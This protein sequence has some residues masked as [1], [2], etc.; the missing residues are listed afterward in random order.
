MIPL[1]T[2]RELFA[3]N[4]WARDRQLEACAALSQEQFQ[5][6]MG[7]SFPSLRDTLVHLVGGEWV[8]L[9]RCHGR[10]PRSLP[11][12]EEFPTLTAIAERW[13]IVQHDFLEYLAGLHEEALIQPLTYM[14]LTG[15]T[16][17]YPLWRALLHV[18]N[19]QTYHRGQVTSILK[20]LGVPPPP[21][22]LLIAHD[23]GLF[24]AVGQR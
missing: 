15:E 8:W 24:D 12:A 7:S 21:V 10:S 1:V 23:M 3:Y 11:A 13:R 20:Q 17:T 14:G 4:Y 5:C 6:P 2:L 19:H 9:E 22:D 18:V 16:W